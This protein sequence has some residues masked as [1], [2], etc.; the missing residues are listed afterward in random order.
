MRKCSNASFFY[1]LFLSFRIAGPTKIRSTQVWCN[2][3][4][5][6][7]PI[8]YHCTLLTKTFDVMKSQRQI[9]SSNFRTLKNPSFCL[10]CLL[11]IK[12]TKTEWIQ[13]VHFMLHLCCH[14]FKFRTHS[15][16]SLLPLR[17]PDIHSLIKSDL[18]LVSAECIYAQRLLT[19]RVLFVYNQYIIVWS[20]FFF[21]YFIWLHCILFFFLYF[22]TITGHI[23]GDNGCSC[24]SNFLPFFLYSFRWIKVCSLS[25]SFEYILRKEVEHPLLNHQWQW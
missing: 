21:V 14:F 2:V 1:N 3:F 9:I 16:A 20:S 23:Q 4:H 25:F 11:D 15:C 7:K 19:A 13:L 22:K 8:L 17:L 18:V 6:P 12:K 24:S 5:T 10:L